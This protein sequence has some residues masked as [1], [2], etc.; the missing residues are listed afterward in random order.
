MAPNEGKGVL[1]SEL[2]GP[3]ALADLAQ[4]RVEPSP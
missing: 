4:V 1:A 2:L 3:C